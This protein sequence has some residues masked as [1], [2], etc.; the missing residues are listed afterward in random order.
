MDG[1]LSLTIFKRTD[2]WRMWHH[3][4][5][6]FYPQSNGF[7]E[8]MVQTLKTTFKKCKPSKSDPY[9][10]L[11]SLRSTPIDVYLPSPVEILFDRQIQ[12]ALPSK[13]KD[14]SPR[15]ADIKQRF[16]DKQ[17]SQKH[18]Y[19]TH[20][21]ELSTQQANTKM[22]AQD[23]RSGTWTPATVVQQSGHP[24]SYMIQFGNSQVLRRNCRHPRE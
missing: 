15:S 12:G 8:Q 22:T 14:T 13:I 9:L 23:T 11:L 19:D 24:R 6:P 1:S 18:Y 16:L 21:K 20:T 7:I 3:K 4:S 10:A 5:S 2:A 17:K